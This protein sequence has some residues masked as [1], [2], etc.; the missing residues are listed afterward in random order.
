MREAFRV[1]YL[2][3]KDAQ[4]SHSKSWDIPIWNVKTSKEISFIMLVKNNVIQSNIP[5][6]F[7]DKISLR[8]SLLQE[9]LK[10]VVIYNYK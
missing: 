1:E 10:N 7:H 8:I 6:N 5:R 2:L 4:S 9:E 3:M